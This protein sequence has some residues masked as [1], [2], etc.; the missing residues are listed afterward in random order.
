MAGAPRPRMDP[1]LPDPREVG[2]PGIGSRQ[3]ALLGQGV[4]CG[5]APG[6]G[7]GL[8]RPPLSGLARVGAADTQ[9]FRSAQ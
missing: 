3:K 2:D 6:G 5:I 7:A 9:R 8:L 4:G 1:C